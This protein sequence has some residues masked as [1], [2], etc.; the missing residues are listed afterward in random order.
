ML[1]VHDRDPREEIGDWFAPL[2]DTF[3]PLA[4]E[5]LV[6]VYQRP[7]RTKGGLYLA[8]VTTTEDRFQGKVGLV[9][10]MGPLAFTED[11]AHHWNG[12]TPKPG[13]WVLFNVGDT[14]PF[15]MDKRRCRM[16]REGNVRA[17]LS[18]PDLVL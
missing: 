8:G 3:Q 12:V 15:E 9:L 4:D 6:A 16:V 18:Q 5:V 10:K 13:D 14:F 17:I 7:E 2:A 11:D 1:M